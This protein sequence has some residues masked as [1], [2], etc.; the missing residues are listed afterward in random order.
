MTGMWTRSLPT[1]PQLLESWSSVYVGRAGAPLTILGSPVPNFCPATMNVGRRIVDT[2]AF[3]TP[4]WPTCPRCDRHLPRGRHQAAPQCST[5]FLRIRVSIPT[6]QT[7]SLGLWRIIPCSPRALCAPA[8]PLAPQQW[9]GAS[10]GDQQAHLHPGTPE[11]TYTPICIN[12][13]PPRPGV[14]RPSRDQ[15]GWK[16]VSRA[17]VFRIARTDHPVPFLYF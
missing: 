6:A 17:R 4:S 11:P 12:P 16:R 3:W 14:R 8:C 7:P 1:V 2:E 10:P 15:V 9:L 13:P 5:G